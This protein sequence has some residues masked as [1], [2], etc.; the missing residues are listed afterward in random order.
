MEPGNHCTLRSP[1][2]QG[3]PMSYPVRVPA[4]SSPGSLLNRAWVV[5]EGHPNI[6]GT[7]ISMNC[8][9]WRNKSHLWALNFKQLMFKQGAAGKEEALRR[10]WPSGE[11]QQRTPS[12]LLLPPMT[13]QKGSRFFSLDHFKSH[14]SSWSKSKRM[15][16]HIHSQSQNIRNV[17]QSLSGYMKQ[18][19]SNFWKTKIIAFFIQ[20]YIWMKA[21]HENMYVCMY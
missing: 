19:A 21:I 6:G 20:M 3:R 10:C 15:E 16:W 1:P 2:T 13:I 14:L 9:G 4:R 7:C 11:G 18:A 17:S 8:C 5:S 12:P